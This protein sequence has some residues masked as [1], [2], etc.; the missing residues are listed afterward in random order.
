MGDDGARGLLEIHRRQGQTFGQDEATCAVFGMP[1]AAQRLGA[2]TD[3]LPPD[4]VA[5]A[6]HRAVAEIRV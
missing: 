6:I 5:R 3:L 1:Q 2:V 4:R